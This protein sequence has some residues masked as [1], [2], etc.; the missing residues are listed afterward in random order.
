MFIIIYFFK[1]VAFSLAPRGPRCHGRR[2]CRPPV[3]CLAVN[4]FLPHTTFNGVVFTILDALPGTFFL[5]ALLSRNSWVGKISC[6]GGVARGQRLPPP[7]Y[8]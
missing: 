1:T 5:F 4:A 8:L 6:A 3:V 7:Y 2:A